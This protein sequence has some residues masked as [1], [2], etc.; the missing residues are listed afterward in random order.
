[1]KKQTLPIRCTFSGEKEI[2]ELLLNSFRRYVERMIE[3]GD[4]TQTV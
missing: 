2:Q 3:D 4:P 1:M